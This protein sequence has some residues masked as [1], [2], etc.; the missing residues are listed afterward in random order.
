[1]RPAERGGVASSKVG[2]TARSQLLGML[3]G[4][5]G[6]LTGC[7]PVRPGP[8]AEAAP[9]PE[10]PAPEPPTP[11]A[12]EPA[13]PTPIPGPARAPSARVDSVRPGVVYHFAWREEGPWAIHVVEVDPRTCGVRVRSMAANDRVVGA[14]TTTSLARR[15]GPSGEPALIAI[16]AD[17]FRADP[18]G[19]QEGPQ[20]AS[21]EVV[22]T[23]GAYGPSVAARF[24]IRQPVFGVARGG[25]AFVGEGE[26]AG[27]VWVRGESRP[28][29]R[30]NAPPGRDSLT[31][32]N[33]YAGAVT[34]A[35]TGVVEVV[36][37]LAAGP[38]AAGDTARAAVVRVD[39]LPAGVAIPADGMVL[40]GRGMAVRW[41]QALAPGDSVAWTLPVAGAPGPVEDL[42][43][44]FPLLLRDGRPAVERVP[45]IREAFAARRHPRSA[46]ALRRDGTV[47][48]VAVDGRQPGYSDGMTLHELTQ[49]LLE[50]G[51]MDALNLDG[52]GST[53]L[54]IRGALVNRPSDPVERPVANALVVPGPGPEECPAAPP[55]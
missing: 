52:G 41:L 18:L 21:G 11:V 46:V 47:L 4:C 49:L 17:F 26:V 28:L 30:V 6:I 15:G 42:V 1:V 9:A 44:G 32:Y 31:L 13:V 16:N 55:R 43:G 19:V 7:G 48:L 53:T 38:G 10:R 25:R 35:D 39:T 54:A 23:E 12:P 34:P 8:G 37:R 2:L 27:E 36:V 29:A 51:A 14:E 40:A 5:L 22:V 33:R 45:R 20:V 3:V 50:L 24:S